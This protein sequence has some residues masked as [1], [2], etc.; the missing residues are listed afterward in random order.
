MDVLK[1]ASCPFA[2]NPAELPSFSL[3]GRLTDGSAGGADPHWNG[4]EYM[5]DA[6][7]KT[8]D[9]T[10]YLYLRVCEY[11]SAEDVEIL[12]EELYAYAA[13][14]PGECFDA[15]IASAN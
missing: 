14:F 11:E 5:S 9:V 12:R 1:L 2:M 4:S 10:W 3:L 15:P 7:M 6:G 8:D 13:D